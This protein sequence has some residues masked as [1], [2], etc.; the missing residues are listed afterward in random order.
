MIH[1][2]LY[3]STWTAM[4]QQDSNA[5]YGAQPS[6]LQ[7]YSPA[8]DAGNFYPGARPSLDG[9]MQGSMAA[10][11]GNG[12]AAFGG[13]IQVQGPWWTAFG[14][15]GFEGE[16]PLLEELGINFSH[17][18]DKSMTVLN[19]LR[20]IDDRIMDDADLAGPVLFVFCFALVLLLVR[21]HSSA[22]YTSPHRCA[23]R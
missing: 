18:R 12:A 16:P 6:N 2:H 8:G 23:V 13:N 3:F 14:T 10:P 22:R 20:A 7:F 4:W 11:T 5:Y 17:I 9:N 15:G 21:A 19:P 1:S